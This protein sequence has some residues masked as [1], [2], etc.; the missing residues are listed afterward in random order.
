VQWR[1][2][3]GAATNQ[4]VV[5]GTVPLYLEVSR[6]TDTSGTTP[7]TYYSALTSPDGVTWTTVPGSAVAMTLQANYLDGIAVTSHDTSQLSAVGLSAV[8]IGTTSSEP[9]GVCSAAYTCV[10]I[11]AAT[12][13]G[14]QTQ[15][16]TGWTI[17]GGGGD[18]AGT[19]DQFRFVEQALPGDGTV[20]ARLVS[21]SNVNA[22]TKSGLMVRAD[23]TAGA[24]YY[25][26]MLTPG[27]GLVVQYR[28]AAGAVTNQ[29]VVLSGSAA[30]LYLSITRTGTTFSA[31][32]SPDGIA[33]TPVAGSTVPLSGLAGSLLAGMVVTSHDTSLLATATFTAVNI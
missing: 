21:L 6:W 18:I 26:L 10:D 9:P 32:T 13:A 33:W 24:A 7:V 15:T 22:W 3:Q 31:S 12:P 29:P 23:T 16:S 4:I 27:N 5:P 14:T 17:Q 2:I 11:G 25:A 30:P 28:N 1:S 8:K 20:S 19:S